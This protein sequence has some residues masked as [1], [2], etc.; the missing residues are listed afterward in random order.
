MLPSITRITSASK[1]N[2]ISGLITFT[3]FILRPGIPSLQLH[4]GLL[5]DRVWGSVLR[6]RLAFPH[7]GFAPAGEFELCSTRLCPLRALW[8][9]FS[10]HF[11]NLVCTMHLRLHGENRRAGIYNY[12]VIIIW[13]ALCRWLFCPLPPPGGYA[14][15]LSDGERNEKG[16]SAWPE[17]IPCSQS[18]FISV[19]LRFLFSVLHKNPVCTMRLRLHGSMSARGITVVL[20]H[21]SS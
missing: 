11:K 1:F 2:R 17:F 16:D 13:V 9:L 4:I 18:A 10:A 7:A 12:N 8:F 6:W 5:P 21:F 20:F 19:H 3:S 14:A 15:L